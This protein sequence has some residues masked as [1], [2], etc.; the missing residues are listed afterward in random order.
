M[1]SS[2][3]AGVKSIRTLAAFLG[4]VLK[5]GQGNWIIRRWTGPRAAKE[6]GTGSRL[7]IEALNDIEI[8]LCNA[9]LRE[10][11][12][13]QAHASGGLV[14]SNHTTTRYG[15]VYDESHVNVLVSW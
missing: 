14:T 1:A 10:K 7:A 8:L 9:M 3:E 6:P 5:D 15:M 11:R 13:K 2:L 12:Q 4:R